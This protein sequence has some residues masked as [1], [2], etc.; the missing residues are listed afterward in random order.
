MLLN[1]PSFPISFTFEDTVALIEDLIKARG[2]TEFEVA[3]ITL[4]YTPYWIFNYTAF[5]E[6]ISEDTKAKVVSDFSEGQIAMNAET[7]EFND[8]VAGLMEGYTLE[9]IRK[10]EEN[11]QF[12]INH[13]RIEEEQVKKIAPLKLAQKM[14]LGR[15][16]VVISGLTM[17]YVPTWIVNISVAEGVFRIEVNAVTGETFGEEEVPEREKGWMEVTQETL[18]ELKEPGAW[19]RYSSE[20]MGSTSQALG[21][22][23]TGFL[24]AFWYNRKLQITILVIILLIVALDVMGYF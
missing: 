23:L 19:L 11:Y 12:Q 18:E 4:V 5:Q 7:G 10:P 16:N 2:W 22:S 1:K 8:E 15:D 9:R 24:S 20:I 6:A 3:D 21:T 13:P 14:Q 17:A